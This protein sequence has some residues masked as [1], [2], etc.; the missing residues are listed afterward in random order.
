MAT[1]GANRLTCP[2]I[3]LFR[4]RGADVSDPIEPTEST[5][6]VAGGRPIEAT[7]PLPAAAPIQPA[8]PA[9]PTAPT[10]PAAPAVPVSEPPTQKIA[11][12][13]SSPSTVDEGP[14]V[15]VTVDKS[16]GGDE[17]TLPIWPQAAP[18]D[19]PAPTA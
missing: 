3:D 2:A 18:I 13:G 12:S 14:T 17:A 7:V 15:A 16:A 19:P 5:E 1:A 10:E 9:G 11:A 8:V 6:P 4:T